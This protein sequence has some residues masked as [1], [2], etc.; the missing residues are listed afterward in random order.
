MNNKKKCFQLYEGVEHCWQKNMYIFTISNEIWLLTNFFIFD[1][2]QE[3]EL[4]NFLKKKRSGYYVG[5]L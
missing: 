1:I 5:K 3:D 4:R 2:L